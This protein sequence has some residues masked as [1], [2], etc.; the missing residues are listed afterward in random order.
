MKVKM[1]EDFQ[2]KYYACPECKTKMIK[3]CMIKEED[4][5]YG[6]SAEYIYQCPKCK[7]IE[8]LK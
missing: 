5:D 8:I 1:S 7:N 6:F 2:K 4:Y 3:K